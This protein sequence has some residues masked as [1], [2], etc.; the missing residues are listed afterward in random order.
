MI[1]R[2]EG[3]GTGLRL[4]DDLSNPWK[5]LDVGGSHARNAPMRV[6]VGEAQGVG[7]TID[8][9]PQDVARLITECGHYL[10]RRLS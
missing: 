5:C 2:Y 7:A 9:E 1:V 10:A 6:Y 4:E 8:L 3:A